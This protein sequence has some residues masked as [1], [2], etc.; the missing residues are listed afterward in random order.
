MSRLDVDPESGPRLQSSC[1]VIGLD[2]GA[3]L[4]R[5]TD[6]ATCH[7]RGDASR[8]SPLQ[9]AMELFWLKG[10]SDTPIDDLLR[11]SGAS[12]CGLYTALGDR[13]VSARSG[14]RVTAIRS[15][16]AETKRRGSGFAS[17]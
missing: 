15:S 17:A 7:E 16:E 3:R 14:R 1:A 8:R 9:R 5:A 10:Y 13:H 4:R 2:L 12:R 11:A 6:R